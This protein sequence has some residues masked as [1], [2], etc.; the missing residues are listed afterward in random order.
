MKTHSVWKMRHFNTF[1]AKYQFS[2][3]LHIITPNKYFFAKPE[4]FKSPIYRVFQNSCT[5][6]KIPW[7]QCFTKE[8]LRHWFGLTKNFS[9]CSEFLLNLVVHPV[10]FR[11]NEKSCNWRKITLACLKGGSNPML[12]EIMLGGIARHDNLSRLDGHS[13]FK[14]YQRPITCLTDVVLNQDYF[15]DFTWNQFWWI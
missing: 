13:I 1:T 7:S 4:L 8:P 15:F 9:H 6:P 3:R 14:G 12:V 2:A 11:Y 10:F 5:F